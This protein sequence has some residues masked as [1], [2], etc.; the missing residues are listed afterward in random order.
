MKTAA[1]AAVF[2]SLYYNI[3]RLELMDNTFETEA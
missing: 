1:I 2:M 3:H